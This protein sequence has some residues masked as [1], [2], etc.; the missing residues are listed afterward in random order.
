M[1]ANFVCVYLVYLFNQLPISYCNVH[2]S[3][4]PSAPLLP[5]WPVTVDN[6]TSTSIYIH[7]TNLTSYLGR[8]V[9]EYIVLLNRK[10]DSALA[11]KVTHGNQLSTEITGLMHLTNYTVE[12]FGVDEQG[13]PYRTPAVNTRTKK[14]N[15]NNDICA[16]CADLIHFKANCI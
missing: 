13:Q 2:V 15:E 9:Q 7:W 11:H 1:R 4:F 3:I 8:P 5:G 10:N 14:G 16:C 6:I 12:V